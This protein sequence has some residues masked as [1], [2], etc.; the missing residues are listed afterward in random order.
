[1]GQILTM[2]HNEALQQ[3]ATERYLLNEMPPELRESFEEHMFDCYECAMDVRA[4]AAFAEEAT[5][6]LPQILST[7]HFAA[8]NLAEASPD[9]I[10]VAK[11]SAQAISE[12]AQKQVLQKKEVRKQNRSANDWFAWLRPTFSNLAF[13]APIFAALLVCHRLSEPVYHA[14]HAGPGK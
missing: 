9:M 4:A 3:M 14:R 7:H 8:S 11:L 12:V 1:M 6:Q 10:G 2:D 13:A 5:V